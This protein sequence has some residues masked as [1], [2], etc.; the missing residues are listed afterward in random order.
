MIEMRKTKVGVDPSLRKEN[1]LFRGNLKGVNNLERG[2]AP[3]NLGKLTITIFLQQIDNMILYFR[4]NH[5]KTSESFGEFVKAVTDP[6][7]F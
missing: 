1:E 2:L 7:N 3:S 6:N 5:N 4:Y